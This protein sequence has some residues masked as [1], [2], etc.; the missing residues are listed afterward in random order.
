[1]T[2]PLIDHLGAL[3]GVMQLLNRE[4]GVFDAADES[5]A[6]ALAAQCA[7]ALSRVRMTRALIAGELMRQEM[8]LAS[9]LQRSTLPAA[10]PQVPGYSMHGSFLPASMTGGD[11]YDLA[12]I[13]QGMLMLLADATGHGIG[14]AL[15]V[16]QMHAMLRMAFRLGADLETA[17]CQVNDRLAE[18]LPE[19]RFVTAFVGL[20]D[21]HAHRLRFLSGGQGP[22]LHFH[23]AGQRCTSYRATSFPMGAS[24]IKLLR[25]AVELALEPGDWLVLLSDGI[26]EFADAAGTLFGRERVEQVVREHHGDTPA[27]LAERLMTAVHAHACGAPQDDDITLVLLRRDAAS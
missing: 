20:L 18:I 11:T 13:P 15:S 3:V 23:A 17:F 19:G 21:V 7:V 5:L 25:P 4:G 14:P 8:A 12:L 26:Y 1:M 22:I 24:P 9:L 6:E 10:L 2:L 27:S 16:T